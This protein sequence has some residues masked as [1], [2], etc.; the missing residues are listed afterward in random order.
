MGSCCVDELNIE[1]ASNPQL[2][3]D[4]LVRMILGNPAILILNE[5]TSSVDT[6]TEFSYKAQCWI[7]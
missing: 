7:L 5:A 1:P 4:G 3:A 6:P 2:P